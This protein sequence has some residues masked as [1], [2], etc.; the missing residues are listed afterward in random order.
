[1]AEHGE[2]EKLSAIH[3]EPTHVEQEYGWSAQVLSE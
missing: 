3:P 1:L 2:I